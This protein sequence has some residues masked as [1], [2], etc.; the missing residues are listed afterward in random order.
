VNDKPYRPATTGIGAEPKRNDPP[1]DDVE[2]EDPIELLRALCED[3]DDAEDVGGASETDEAAPADAADGTDA[4]SATSPLA[5]G[6]EAAC[7]ALVAATAANPGA[8]FA[9]DVVCALAQLKQANREQF[10]SLRT[11]LKKAGCRVT[12]LDPLIAE[13]NGEERDGRAPSQANIM[14]ALAEAAELFHTPD[15]VAYADIEING[16]RVTWPVCSTGF[17]RWLKRRFFEETG[18]APNGEAVATAIGTIEA[19]ALHDT[20]IREVFVRVGEL[21]GK[22]YLDMCDARW[23]AIEIDKAGWRI[24]DRPAVR[25]RRSPDMRPLPEPARD[26]SVDG[27]RPLLNIPEGED[28]DND[29]ILSV[30][31]QLG[32]LRGRGP[33]PIEVIGGGQGSAKSTRSSMLRSTIDP[34]KPALRGLPRDERDLVIAAHKQHVLAFDNASGLY[35]WLSDA[36]CRIAS[37]AGFG[38]RALWTDQDEVLFSGARPII[39]NGIEE[40]VERPD[41]AERSI[42]SVCMKI[43]SKDRLEEDEVWAAFDAAHASVLGALLDAVAVGLKRFPEIR[44]PELPRMADFAHWVIACETALW[45]EGDFLRAYNTNI[46]GAVESVL[47][48]SP[49]AVAVREMMAALT[50][51]APPKTR[52]EG[53]ASELLEKLTDRVTKRVAE[54]KTWPGNGRAL[55]GR[56]TRAA[57]F[58]REVAIDITYS[59]EGHDRTRTIVITTPA[60]PAPAAV[61][62]ATAVANKESFASIP[63]SPSAAG[64][65]SSKNN[66]LA[67]VAADAKP[68]LRTQSHS[69]RTQTQAAATTAAGGD[70]GADANRG[71]WTQSAARREPYRPQL[72][73]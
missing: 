14:V 40:I 71:L 24:V 20:P 3:R 61:H 45:K 38:T 43:D 58:L 29:F 10:E 57:T 11:R 39:L 22:I 30:A 66:N 47:E 48:A 73:H 28:G 16:H 64:V 55:R 31:F 32:C 51:E 62:T 52:W 37:G 7:D 70:T 72:K 26:G 34:R 59:R 54:S 56:L 44:P 15:E 67:E 8:P 33:Y 65:A 1:I 23:R 69:M 25:F 36:L 50:K 12:E 60:P 27:L 4:K 19:K 5:E 21:G 18:G 42:F 2:A 6:G 35:D 17:R 46:L 49:V 68:L 53:T 9:P 13:E 41:L 63:S